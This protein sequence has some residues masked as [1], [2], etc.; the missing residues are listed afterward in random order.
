M[1]GRALRGGTSGG[2]PYPDIVLTSTIEKFVIVGY[3]KHD[4]SIISHLLHKFGHLKHMAVIQSAG[5]FVKNEDL[6]TAHDSLTYSK[7]LALTSG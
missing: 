6:L 2:F 5:R 1:G 3:Y 4:I 7:T